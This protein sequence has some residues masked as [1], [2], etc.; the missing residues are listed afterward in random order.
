MGRITEGPTPQQNIFIHFSDRRQT[1]FVWLIYLKFDWTIRKTASFFNRKKCVVDKSQIM[2]QWRKGRESRT[3]FNYFN[4]AHTMRHRPSQTLQPKC[5][6]IS[7]MCRSRPLQTTADNYKSYGNHAYSTSY[8][9]RSHKTT[10]FSISFSVNLDTV[11]ALE[12]KSRKRRLY[13]TN[14]R[15]S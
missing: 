8:G 14:C 3:R 12:F 11:P 2:A 1:K 9:R 10:N 5:F 15:A 7:A 13:L 4:R 6:H